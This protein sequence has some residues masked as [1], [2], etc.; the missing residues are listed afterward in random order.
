MRN[1]FLIPLDIQIVIKCRILIG[2]LNGPLLLLLFNED[3]HKLTSVSSVSDK[4]NDLSL[5]FLKGN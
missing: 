4:K 2:I 1:I 3:I 5:L